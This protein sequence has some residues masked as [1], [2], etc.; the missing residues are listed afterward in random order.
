M[1]QLFLIRYG[2]LAL[3]G[4]NRDLFKKRLKNNIKIKLKGLRTEI[5]DKL[6]RLY[7]R[8]DWADKDRIAEVLSNTFGIV[9][10]S[11]TYKTAKNMDQIEQ[12]VIR[13]CD[14]V[15]ETNP[16]SRFRITVKRIDKNFELNSYQLASRLGNLIL[17][18]CSGLEVNL[19]NYDWEISC[20]IRE[21]AYIYGPKMASQKGLPVGVQGRGLLLLSG[22]IDSPVAG[23]L[24]AKRGL[25]VSV[26]Y[27]NTPPFTS[28]KAL[29]KVKDLSRALFK[30]LPSM[31]LFVV[32]FTQTQLKIK[33]AVKRG[34]VTL[35][36]R[37]C[38]MSIASLLAVNNGFKCLVTGESLGQ[39]AS[40]TLESIH[41][42]GSFA[43]LPVFRPLIGLDKEEIIT[44]AKRIGTYDISILPYDDCCTVFAPVHPLIRPE[45]T[46]MRGIFD[47]IGILPV[48][49]EAVSKT[50][51]VVI[52]KTEP[53]F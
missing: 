29:Q 32:P 34:E 52:K 5:Y 21:A 3:K 30:F 9:G 31:R 39:V 36:S 7:I 42:T 47:S 37:A 18:H 26:V 6:S 2:E 14:K 40:Q 27:F 25:A 43:G 12:A 15:R 44:V 28:D 10:Y 35:V 1:E 16:G 4:E 38:M 49:N 13:L 17:D 46:S 22:G 41:F 11:E 45:F 50:E 53:G 48:L 33:E 19:N 51:M 23:Y 24:M 20:E 8:C